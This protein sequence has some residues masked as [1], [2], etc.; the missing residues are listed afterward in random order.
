M[1]VSTLMLAALASARR[2][3]VVVVGGGAAGMFASIAAARSGATVVVLESGSQPLRKVRISGGGRCNVMHDP[4]TWQPRAAKE[5]LTARYPRGAQELIGCFSRAGKHRAFSPTDTAAW[6]EAEGVALKRE[7]DGRVFPT[8]DDSDT[9]VRALL[10]AAERAGVELVLGAKVL[11]LRALDAPAD[12]AGRERFELVVAQR[13]GDGEERLRC[14]SVVL[15]TGSASHALAAALGHAPSPL[16]PSL[17]SFRLGAPSLLDSS[18]AGLSV[19]DAELTLLAEAAA[20]GE[21]VKKA[22]KPLAQARGPLL[23]THRGVSGPAALRLSS[24]GAAPLAA[25]GYRGTLAL[26]LC[27]ALRPAEVAACLEAFARGEHR[28]KQVGTISP[29]ELPRR[30]W[31]LVVAAAAEGAPPAAGAIDPAKRWEQ[32]SRAEL[33]GLEARLTRLPLPFLGKDSNKDEFVTAGG[34]KLAEVDTRTMGSK[35]APGLFFA[36]EVLDIDGVTGGHNFQSAWTTGFIA[37]T[38]AAE[39]ARGGSPVSPAW[40]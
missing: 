8:T 20:E 30:L 27:P 4:A 3:A 36:G 18:L 40:Q 19:A 24:F 37:G 39:L 12:A 25:C 38:C 14:G 26:N 9:I 33:R 31:R 34:I 11:Q 23:V 17:F 35:A 13:G 32:V 10:G 28:L 7:P 1:V 6:F 16:I 22:R 5:L 15:A 2:P 29:F 21:A